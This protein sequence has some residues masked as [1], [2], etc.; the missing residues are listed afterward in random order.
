M[1][2][3]G[4]PSSIYTDIPMLDKLRRIVTWTVCLAFAA[5]IVGG[6]HNGVL[7][8]AG[9]GQTKIESIC[10]PGCSEEATECS[11]AGSNAIDHKHD[12][13][14]ECTD[15]PLG[16]VLKLA[17]QRTDSDRAATAVASPAAIATP[18]IPNIHSGAERLA[19]PLAFHG[20]SPPALALRSTILI[21]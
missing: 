19:G 1:A 15:H 17:R 10:L 12:G 18:T 3:D 21:C 13:C 8:I 2:I 11:S 16:G 20:P 9:D 7:C 5:G 4:R 14:Y 6:V